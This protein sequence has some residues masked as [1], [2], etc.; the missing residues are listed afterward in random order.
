MIKFEWNSKKAR[1]NETKHK[2]SFEEARS[3]FFDEYAQQFYDSENS[4]N[5]DRFFMLG[6]SIKS[7]VLVVVHCEREGGEIIRIISARKA[8]SKERKFYQGAS[9]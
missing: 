1:S 5:E 7:R 3:V 8:T 9:I 2:V 4:D 6:K